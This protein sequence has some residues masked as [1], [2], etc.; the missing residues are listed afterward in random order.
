MRRKVSIGGGVNSN[1]FISD[2]IRLAIAERGGGGG[3]EYS[4]GSSQ[5]GGGIGI[6]GED[7]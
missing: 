3:G 2:F 4:S 5:G 1:F 6:G 7:R